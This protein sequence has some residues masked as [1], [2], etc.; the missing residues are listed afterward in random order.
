MQDPTLNETLKEETSDETAEEK[1]TLQQKTSD[2]QIDYKA[3]FVESQREAIRLKKELDSFKEAQKVSA[4]EPEEGETLDEIVERKVQEKIAPLTKE[5]EE[6]K[7]DNFLKKNPEA[8]DYLKDI[9]ENYTKMPGKSVEVKLE[10]AFVLAKKDAMK[11]AGKKEM[12]FTLYQKEQA[13]A[14]G[15][16]VSAAPEEG[17]PDLTEEERKVAQ[18]MGIK[19]ETYAKRKLETQK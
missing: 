18:S 19:E 2:Q 16:G 9:E 3:R 12:A 17:L 4:E 14:S 11:Q 8:M 10:N 15:G 6:A 5:Q 1:D 13:I 7:V